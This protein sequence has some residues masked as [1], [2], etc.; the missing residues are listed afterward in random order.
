MVDEMDK[1]G[2]LQW[3]CSSSVW[4]K[5]EC[6]AE[7][8]Q[9]LSQSCGIT[10]H[11]T[12]ALRRIQRPSRTFSLGKSCL[13]E[14]T[15]CGSANFKP[16]AIHFGLWSSWLCSRLPSP[17]SDVC[18]S[19]GWG[20]GTRN[21]VQVSHV[22]GRNPAIWAISRASQGERLQEAGME[23]RAG[24]SCDIL[25]ARPNACAGYSSRL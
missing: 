20:P 6:C 24:L 21:S 5:T 19:Q 10:V 3:R 9:G 1:H 16:L 23:S 15:S 2:C 14:Y 7:A 4:E 25:A 12:Q 22:N 11:W 17:P 13:M 18:N 8:C